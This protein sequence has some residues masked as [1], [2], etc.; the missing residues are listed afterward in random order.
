[1]K[2]FEIALH[3]GGLSDAIKE[4]SRAEEDKGADSAASLGQSSLGSSF[5]SMD[6]KRSG[7]RR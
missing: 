2:A 5:R 1:M 7:A 6:Q 4:S 3:D